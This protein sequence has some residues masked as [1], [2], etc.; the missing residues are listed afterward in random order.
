MAR[1]GF[2]GLG[3]MGLPMA[4]N[5][6]AAGHSVKAY[7]IS[8][9][10]HA[11]ATEAGI[12]PCNRL[13]DA[14]ADA[15][16]AISMVPTGRHVHEIFL[17][18]QGALTRLPPNA[19][20]IDSSTINI[21]EARALHEAALARGIAVLDAPVS[22]GVMGAEAGT[23]TFM[24]GGNAADLERA[25]PVLAGMGR[26]IFHAGEAGSGQV[27][28]ICN[29]MMA[30]VGMIVTSEAFA[31]AKR[32][33]MAPETLRDIVATSTGGCFA[34]TNYPPVPGLLPNV[35]SSRD[36]RNGFA[37]VLMLKDLRLAEQ[38]GIEAGLPLP[39]GQLAA[40]MYGMFCR[41]GHGE[42]DYSA[43]IKMV[44]GP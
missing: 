27:A 8:T 5:L 40:A 18:E 15:E 9:A 22:G 3:R 30:A 34:L 2:I 31:L 28:K 20:V 37:A 1:I 11:A 6:A 21:S 41:A 33:G 25:R 10:Y 38:A 4:R 36:Y 32:F 26:N 35:P 16:F 42:L 14:I 13:D 23:L 17:G 43:I 39:L 44:E 19:L 12:T 24:V 7:D 29:N